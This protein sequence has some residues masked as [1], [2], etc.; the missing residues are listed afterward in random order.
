MPIGMLCSWARAVAAVH[1]AAD[2]IGKAAVTA[3]NAEA[4][5]RP[6]GICGVSISAAWP[7]TQAI[8]SG[9]ADHAMLVLG[10]TFT[11]IELGVLSPL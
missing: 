4:R 6:R 11:E 5:P 7:L 3:T 9:P 2:Q 10:R 1:T 8:A